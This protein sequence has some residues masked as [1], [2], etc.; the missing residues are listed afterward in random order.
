L[1]IVAGRLSIHLPHTPPYKPQGRGKIERFFRTVRDQW[2]PEKDQ[3]SIESLNSTLSEWLDRYHHSIHGS[4]K[5]S[6]LAKRIGIPRAVRDVPAVEDL[7]RKFR[8]HARRLV[9][10]NG[11]ITL[12]GKMYD[13]RDAIPGTWVDVAYLPWNLDEIWVGVD[14]SPA[15]RVDLYRNAT[16]H[17]NTPIQNNGD[18]DNEKHQ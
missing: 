5:M 9:H 12:E 15:R 17:I 11:T 6:P 1:K 10:R 14:C 16:H 4:L 7:E 8:M 2:L 13:I 18:K 3:V